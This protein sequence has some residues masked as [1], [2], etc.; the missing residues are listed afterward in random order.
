MSDFECACVAVSNMG[1]KKALHSCIENYLWG[2]DTV[3]PDLS[4]W[5]HWLQVLQTFANEVNKKLFWNI[6]GDETKKQYK[7]YSK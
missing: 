6:D 3:E 4:F 5:E 1:G 7:M 2:N